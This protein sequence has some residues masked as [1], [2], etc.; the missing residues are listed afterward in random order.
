VCK[1]KNFFRNDHILEHLFCF[2]LKIKQNSS[3]EPSWSYEVLLCSVN[4]HL[5]VTGIKSLQFRIIKP[6]PDDFFIPS[7]PAQF[8]LQDL[9]IPTHKERM[10]G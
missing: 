8:H 3:D 5:Y 9:Q 6:V 7:V 1:D 4:G 2:V 10:G